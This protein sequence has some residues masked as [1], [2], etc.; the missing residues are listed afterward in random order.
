MLKMKTNELKREKAR[1][2]KGFPSSSIRYFQIWGLA[3]TW[4]MGS[5]MLLLNPHSHIILVV[6]WSPFGPLDSIK[7]KVVLVTNL[8]Q[9]IQ[10]KIWDLVYLLWVMSMQ[11]GIISLICQ[12]KL[13]M[14]EQ[15][16]VLVLERLVFANYFLQFHIDKLAIDDS[17]LSLDQILYPIQI[18]SGG[19][20]IP[21]RKALGNTKWL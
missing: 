11:H 13:T 3:S 5:S 12:Y 7:K 6:L 17:I 18:L 15:R 9:Y 20:L 16:V 1:R 2:T 14:R 19:F 10:V 21:C 4:L 8:V